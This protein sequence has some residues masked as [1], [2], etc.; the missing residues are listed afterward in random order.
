MPNFVFSKK[1]DKKVT[2]L[3]DVSPSKSKEEVKPDPKSNPK[4]V[5]KSVKK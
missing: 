3:A 2:K 1:P 4:Q 5:K